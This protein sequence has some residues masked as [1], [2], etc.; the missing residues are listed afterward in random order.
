[1][2]LQTGPT[3]KQLLFTDA[4]FDPEKLRDLRGAAE[5]NDSDHG[6]T[7]LCRPKR[8]GLSPLHG[9]SDV[10][11]DLLSLDPKILSEVEKILVDAIPDDPQDLR[12]TNDVLK[13][14]A[15]SVK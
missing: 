12:T 3:L 14:S 11:R 15:N 10:R 2:I 13:A 8:L 6:W 5:S 7:N 9:D 1:S 4:A